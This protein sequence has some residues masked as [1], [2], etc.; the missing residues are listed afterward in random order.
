MRNSPPLHSSHE[1]R[2]WKAS[3]TLP[4]QRTTELA[5]ALPDL[6]SKQ[7]GSQTL[8]TGLEPRSSFHSSYSLK[9]SPSPLFL[10]FQTQSPSDSI[11]KNVWHLSSTGIQRHSSLPRLVSN[12]SEIIFTDEPDS[13]PNT[14]AD[15]SEWLDGVK[16]HSSLKATPSLTQGSRYLALNDTANNDYSGPVAY[17]THVGAAAEHSTNIKARPELELRLV[18]G[19]TRHIGGTYE[20]HYRTPS[21]SLISTYISR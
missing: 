20:S 19:G 5:E 10:P 6:A 8:T 11:S 12:D 14:P 16:A 7:S 13:S 4:D 18:G 9:V 1:R 15:P 17:H 21:E 3:P 2:S